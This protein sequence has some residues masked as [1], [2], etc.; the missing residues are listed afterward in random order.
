MG[1]TSGMYKKS[2]G[3]ASK[4]VQFLL[5]RTWHTLCHILPE[6]VECMP[7]I[8]CRFNTLSCVWKQCVS[9][10]FVAIQVQIVPKRGWSFGTDCLCLSTDSSG[11]SFH[12][13]AQGSAPQQYPAVP[14]GLRTGE[15]GGLLPN[16]RSCLRSFL[17]SEREDWG[18]PCGIPCDEEGKRSEM[19]SNPVSGGYM[20]RRYRQR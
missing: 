15:S 6:K 10:C 20:A 17:R 8:F 18:I 13:P 16:S 9:P 14:E 5:P 19:A 1:H 3:S 4:A 7:D 12:M 11:I 2:Q